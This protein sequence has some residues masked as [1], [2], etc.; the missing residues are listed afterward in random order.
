MPIS[1]SSRALVATA[2]IA[3]LAGCSGG[4]VTSPISSVGSQ[5][6]N[7]QAGQHTQSLT[8]AQILAKTLLVKPGVSALLSH[9]TPQVS[10]N[11][12]FAGTV[13]L[14]DS[15]TNEVYKITAKG[16]VTPVG[17]GWS[18]PQGI[19]VDS[20]GNVYIADTA[21]SRVVELSKAGKPVAILSDPGQY[22]AG[23]TIA[24]DGTVGV[25]NIISTSGGE[26]SVSFYTAGS[27]SPECTSSGVLSEDYF[28]G[29]DS[30]DNFYFD[31]FDASTG[32]ITLATAKPCGSVSATGASASLAFPGGVNVYES[33]KGKKAV[34]TVGWGDQSAYVVYQFE[35]PSYSPEATIPLGGGSDEVQYAVAKDKKYIGS[36]DAGNADLEI[37]PFP[38]GGSSPSATVTG[39]SLPIGVGFVPTGDE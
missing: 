17:S 16:K 5:S 4:S 33:G 37:W 24:K 23:V 25:T 9:G 28:I 26:G 38:S 20:K 30:S 7:H 13:Y 31:G 14:S 21:N 15:G 35:L 12:D 6:I 27:T 10:P 32:A 39:F 34:Q 18:E 19:G 29:V 22:P 2:T 1:T 8:H 3:L 11:A 36:G